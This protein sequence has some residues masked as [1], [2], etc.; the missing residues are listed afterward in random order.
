MFILSLIYSV[1][2]WMSLEILTFVMFFVSYLPLSMET[3]YNL[4][5]WGLRI[6]FSLF[7][8]KV[9]T[10][11]FDRLRDKDRV[12]LIANHPGLIDPLYLIAYFPQ[13]LRFVAS[14]VLFTVPFFGRLVT[15]V[16]AIPH[17]ADKKKSMVY[18]SQLLNVLKKGE[19]VMLF[20]LEIRDSLEHFQLSEEAIAPLAQA[21]GAEVVSITLLG[22]E[23]VLPLDNAILKPGRIEV[24]VGGPNA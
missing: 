3:M 10:H 13:R 14:T 20:P 2:F 22:T 7:F 18:A 1:L 17:S 11:G 16:G 23:L 4:I 5:R 24:V 6:I 15:R 21:L 19:L 12:L 9:R 8:I